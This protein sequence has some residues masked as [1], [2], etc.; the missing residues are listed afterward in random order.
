MRKRTLL[1]VSL[2]LM[3]STN[4]QSEAQENPM[5]IGIEEASKWPS[6]LDAVAAA[7]KNHRV[8]LENDEI[9]V[10][11]V[12]VRAG[13]REELH[14]HRWPSAMI[15]DSRPNYANYDQNGKEIP[16]AVA[17]A[18]VFP[19]IAR[20]PAQ[21]AHKIEVFGGQP[22]PFHA[23]RIEFKKLCGTW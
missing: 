22:Q 10:L 19:V 18:P 8:L 3:F 11:E 1:L 6:E 5:C 21:P 12:T 15:I 13:E 2:S 7:P 20:L 17:G 23:I 14:H 9:R 16:P 4:A